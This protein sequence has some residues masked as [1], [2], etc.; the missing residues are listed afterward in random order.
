MSYRTSLPPLP[1]PPTALTFLPKSETLAVATACKQIVLFDAAKATLHEW[2]LRN[3]APIPEVAGSAE[4]PHHIAC[5]PARPR[6]V[7]LV[8]QSWLCS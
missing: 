3:A 7:V 5:N 8:A 2:S 1:S 4:V 6:T